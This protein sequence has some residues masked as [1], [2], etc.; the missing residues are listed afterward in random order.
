MITMYDM[1]LWDIKL[2]FDKAVLFMRKCCG[3]LNTEQWQV[4]G[5]VD[6]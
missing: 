3:I 6:C 1:S 4:C 2:V 5:V